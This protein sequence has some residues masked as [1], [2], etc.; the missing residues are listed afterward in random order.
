M[1]GCRSLLA[2]LAF[3]LI[4]CPALA[5]GQGRGQGRG[6]GM[7]M[8]GGGGGI[9]LLSSKDVQTDLKMTE[10]QISKVKEL[11]EKQRGMF[12]ELRDLSPEERREKMQE[13]QKKMTEDLNKILSEVQQKRLKQLG[14][15]STHKTAGLGALLRNQDF[16][17]AI[18]LNDEQKDALR[19]IQEDMRKMM[20]EMRGGGDPQEM[21]TKMQEMRKA[22][23]Q[24]LEKLL[25]DAQR[26]KMKEL[27]GEPFKGEF[28]TFG[29]RPGGGGR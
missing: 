6:Q 13:M 5:Q 27:M 7:G 1:T 9:M 14:Y 20:E 24:K 19:A 12:G 4:I 2:V 22:N 11:Q 8:G 23:D 17:S 10:D 18:E 3:G 28:P 16:A 21:R 26:S 25:T 29:R 15:Q